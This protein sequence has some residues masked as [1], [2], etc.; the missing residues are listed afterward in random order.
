MK[1]LRLVKKLTSSFF[2]YI[3]FGC[4]EKWKLKLHLSVYSL[5]YVRLSAA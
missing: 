3:R 2:E 5:V 4:P 1:V